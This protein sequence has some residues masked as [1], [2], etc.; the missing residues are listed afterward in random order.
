[1]STIHRRVV[2]SLLVGLLLT[3]GGA[4]AQAF[5][6]RAITI[7]CAQA[8]GSSIDIIARLVAHDLSEQLKVPVIVVNRPGANGMIGVESVAKAPPDGYTLV[9]GP[10]DAKGQGR[11]V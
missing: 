1:M 7:I 6:T 8:A 5:P 11:V 4:V 9:I 3:A 2:N 10:G